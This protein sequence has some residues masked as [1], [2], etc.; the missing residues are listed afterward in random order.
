MKPQIVLAVFTVIATQV[1]YCAAEGVFST[2]TIGIT[3]NINDKIDLTPPSHITGWSLALGTNT[4][5]GTLHVDSN[6]YW[7]VDIKS[8]QYDGKM[9]EYDGNSY[10]YPGGQSLHDPMHIVYSTKDI[11]LTD[12][13]QPLFDSMAPINQDYVITFSQQIESADNRVNSPSR[14]HIVATFTG[15]L[16]Y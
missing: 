4:K 9:K 13:Y 11:S 16:H 6:N 15:S 7:E 5:N 8:D 12:Q 14:Y 3:G 1:G 10:V 2:A